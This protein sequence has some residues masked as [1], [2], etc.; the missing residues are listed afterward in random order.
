MAGKDDKKNGMTKAEE[1]QDENKSLQ[2]ENKDLRELNKE[3]QA[4]S[5]QSEVGGADVQAL[6]KAMQ[7][8]SEQ[9]EFG[10]FDDVDD[11][12]AQAAKPEQKAAE[13]E[14]KAAQMEQ[15]PGQSEQKEDKPEQPKAEETKPETKSPQP[16]V[17]ETGKDE[18]AVKAQSVPAASQT[19]GSMQ[20]QVARLVEKQ[21][22]QNQQ[23]LDEL[24]NSNLA[25]NN[26]YRQ[27][28]EQLKSDLET[29]NDA[30]KQAGVTYTQM[31]QSWLDA[32]KAEADKQR[33]RNEAQTKRD[34]R[35]RLWGGIAEA[36]SSLVNLMG[37][38]KGAVSQRWDSSQPRWAERADN[39]RRER[40]KKLES[41]R[42][43]MENLQRQKAQ[44]QYSFAKDD[45]DRQSRLATGIAARN[46]QLAQQI[47]KGNLAAAQA[48]AQGAQQNTALGMQG[49]KMLI[50]EQ[51]TEEGRK[52]QWAN[53]GV[54]QSNAKRLKEQNE[55]TQK[56]NGF[57]PETGK[58]W[59][60][61]TKSYDLDAPE[62]IK[63]TQRKENVGDLTMKEIVGVRDELARQMGFDDYENYLH[64]A[65]DRT[66][67]GKKAF[68]ER[69]NDNMEVSR[70]LKLME[71]PEMLDVKD[72]QKLRVSKAF[73]KAMGYDDGT[74]GTS[75]VGTTVKDGYEYD[76]NGFP[77]AKAD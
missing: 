21:E 14:Q 7:A 33:E 35:T 8:Q 13:S 22:E 61:K 58:W 11:T 39:L 45:A 63:G 2:K 3:L 44:L 32:A 42:S 34:D 26:R 76:E 4:Q 29:A 49:L 64:A 1:L 40:D 48:K 68:S 15:K 27:N 57:D 12:P 37:T 71:H 18:K 56:A 46:D 54:A 72:F 24:T 16:V 66:R 47:Y 51:N 6:N 23:Y 31:V 69:A 43:Q 53:V 67:A 52:I 73:N 30:A 55:F 17:E 75:G 62:N 19:G 74:G 65:N 50:D 5:E 25:Y 10:D 41:L 60:A 59:N 36:A 9:S 28:T 20:D 70:L 77:I 38:T